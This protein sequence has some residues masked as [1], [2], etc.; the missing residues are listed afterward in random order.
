MRKIG[1]QPIIFVDPCHAYLGYYTD[2][3]KKKIALLETTIT[4][5]VNLP[6]LDIHYDETTGLLE[7]KYYNKISKYL[8][9]KE[10]ASYEAGKMSLEEIKKAVSNNLFD[11]A[12][13]YQKE[14][15]KNNKDL[16]TDPNQQTYQMLVIDELR[17]QIAPIPAVEE[18]I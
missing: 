5:W 8:T 1:I 16:Y 12:T 18:N 15:Y 7:E 11:R 10:K 2:K 9:E 17:K 3:T 14:N 4:G 6:D 13:E